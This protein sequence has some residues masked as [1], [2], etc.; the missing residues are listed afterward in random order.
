MEISIDQRKAI[1]TIKNYLNLGTNLKYTD[2]YMMKEYE[3]AI[4]ELIESASNIKSL[5]TIGVK[6]KSDGL[7]SVTFTDGIEAWMIT[8]TI[9]MLLPLPYVRMC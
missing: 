1:L 5:K 8:P 4:D 6:S 9:K 7:Q 3:L 2:D